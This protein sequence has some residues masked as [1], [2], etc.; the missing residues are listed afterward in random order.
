MTND[1][2]PLASLRHAL[3]SSD[4]YIDTIATLAAAKA[5]SS[6]SH[7][8]YI[9]LQ[10][11]E[12]LQRAEQLPSLYPDVND[13]PPLYGT[14]ISIK[15]CFDV[16]GTITTCGSRFYAQF[17]PVAANNSWV[18]QRLLDAGAIIPGKTHLHQL[19]YGITGENT[20]YGNSLQ[21]RDPTLL[22]GGSSSGAAASVQEGSAL[23]A[24]GTDTGGSV[25]VP[26]ALCGL[27]GYRSSHGVSRGEERWAEAAH[28]APSFDTLGILFRDLRDGPALAN[29]IFDIAASPA[30][31]HPRIGCVG[32]DFLH[33]AEPEVIEA[34][35][36]WKQQL[37]RHGAI[38]T[39]IDTTF[40]ADSLEIFSHIQA[41]EAAAIHRGHYQHFEPAIAERLAWG[42]SIT[43]EQLVA[44]HKRLAVFRFQMSLIFEQV[45][46]LLVPCAPV[47]KLH[48]G[49]D[50]SKIRPTILRYTTPISLTGLPAVTLP[51]EH[52]GAAFGTGMQLIAAPMQDAPLLAFAASLATHNT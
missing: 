44:L 16:E 27:A 31:S 32:E 34:Y 42:A 1:L 9:A 15:D 37:L 3:A 13:R 40:W 2:S 7:N 35:A 49:H 18:A 51:G 17:N 12:S 25:R 26:A 52:I 11:A 14:T 20:D 29:A 24:I 21:P 50:Q 38:L 5:N 6:A 4:S 36:A 22:T 41:S 33:D 46:L 23:A 19:A 48:A 10:T 28:L 47:S 30:P 43:T 8:T 45:D 39:P